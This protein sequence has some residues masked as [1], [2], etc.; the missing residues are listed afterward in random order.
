MEAVCQKLCACVSVG[1]KYFL[2]LVAKTKFNQSA[3]F[4]QTLTVVGW[5]GG[6]AGEWVGECGR[7]G[8]GGPWGG[9]EVCE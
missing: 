6:Q 5:V 3:N 7:K 1:F 8:G 2:L 4:K 9:G